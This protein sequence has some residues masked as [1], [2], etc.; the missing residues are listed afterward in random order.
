M[1]Q[2]FSCRRGV[3]LATLA[4]LVGVS[5]GAAACRVNNDDLKRWE[6]TEHGPEK[7]AAVLTHDKYDK[8]LRV[9]AA[10]SLVEMKKR[11]GQYVGVDI[12]LKSLIAMPAKDRS[13]II[14]GLWKKL[15]P[16]VAQG[17]QQVQDGKWAD[18]SVVWKDATFSLYS[19][20]KDDRP[21]AQKLDLDP[22][23]SEEMTAALT[24][25]AAGKEGED[26]N[27]RLQ[28]FE[29]RLDNSAQQYGIEQI[30]RAVGIPGT[31]RL[32]S[33]LTAKNAI[34]SQ[35]LDTVARVVT[36]V[37]P[38]AGN[39][40]ETADYEKARDELA[41]NFAKLLLDTV[42]GAYVEAVRA[43]TDDALSKAPAGKDIVAQKNNPE[44]DPAK[45]Q[46]IAYFIKVRDE[47]LQY[48]FS[49]A[50]QVGRK[51][52]VDALFA[53]AG[54]AEATKENRAF[55]LAALEGNF[56][57][58]DDSAMKS[59]IAIA[60]ST[61]P[62]EVKHVALVRLGAYPPE[63]AVQAYYQLFGE[64]NWKVRYDAA[65]Q[66][67]GIM[68]KLGDKSK[69]STKEFLQKLPD[70]PDQKMG[71]GEPSD[72]AK[73][74]SAM[75]KELNTKPLVLAGLNS[76]S[77][78]EKL[79]ALGWYLS[80]GTKEDLPTLEKFADDKDKV[81]QCKEEDDCKWDQGCPVPKSG[82]AAGEVDWK[83]IET[84][85]DYVTYCVKVQIDQR[86]KAPPPK[87]DDKKDDDGKDDKKDDKK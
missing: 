30:L 64:S 11:G 34:K 8:D 71:L 85:G 7:L 77:L 10:W 16:K 24:D 22:K 43:E 1:R 61:A 74:L 41:T 66:V 39:A 49:I 14:S 13:E 36:D 23:V 73:A 54:N 4:L 2:V 78:G 53:L 47:R 17:L 33:L 31:K 59:F 9:E 65:M 56:A 62:D 28:T 29:T 83:K 80:V 70:K 67:L 40:G 27:T 79:V 38:R 48:L 51:P 84:I 50:K 52:V 46:Y 21:G 15:Q 72:Y 82:G 86:A 75:P 12:L 25:W 26:V 32:P 37:K 6:I 18:P 45:N 60:K 20:S 19:S 55:A 81:P 76:K 35:R 3:R 58:T 87:T 57:T 44:K 68:Q 42:A 63:Q 69:T 5:S